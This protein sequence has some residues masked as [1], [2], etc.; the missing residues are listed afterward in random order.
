MKTKLLSCA[1]A[2]L[3]AIAAQAQNASKPNIVF[4]LID[5]LGYG[6]VGCYGGGIVR[7]AEVAL[8][9]RASYESGSSLFSS[10]RD[11]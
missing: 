7:G 6:E 8:G 2:L 4:I 5:Y 3:S 1:F 11:A 10:A 9:T